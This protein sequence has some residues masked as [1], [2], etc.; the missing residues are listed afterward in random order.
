MTLQQKQ[1]NIGKLILSLLVGKE[2]TRINSN[3][4]YL[5]LAKAEL[6]GVQDVEA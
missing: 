2:L 3:S 1:V 4:E 5:V 6:A